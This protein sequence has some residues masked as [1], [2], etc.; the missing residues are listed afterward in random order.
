M[1]DKIP[2]YIQPDADGVLPTEEEVTAG[3]IRGGWDGN[4]LHGRSFLLADGREVPNPVSVEPPLG[5][6]PG[7]SLMDQIEA[8]M[9]AKYSQLSGEDLLEDSEEEARDFDEPEVDFNP[10][11]VYEMIEEYPG[12]PEVQV[13]EEGVPAQTGNTSASDSNAANVRTDAAT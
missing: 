11:S 9:R 13:R 2:L 1:T 7:P 12:V 6:T 8:M 4:P 5:F 3:M 10:A